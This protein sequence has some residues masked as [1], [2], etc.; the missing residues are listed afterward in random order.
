MNPEWASIAGDWLMSN[1]DG[2]NFYN[3]YT[4]APES[5]HIMWTYPLAPGGVVGGNYTDWNYYTGLAYE[6]KMSSPIVIDGKLILNLPLSTASST[7]GAVAID[8]HTGKQLWY[9]NNTR[10]SFAQ[11]YDYNSP[12]QFGVIPYLWST[13]STYNCYDPM[14]GQWLFSLNNALTGTNVFGPN[15]EILVYVLNGQANT[16]LKWNSTKA[17]MYYQQPGVMAGGNVWQWRPMMNKTMDWTKGIEW[18]VT[19]KTYNQPQTQSIKK[20]SPNVILSTTI[21]AF[22]LPYTSEMEIAYSTKDG[23]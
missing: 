7:G 5:G 4:S 13:G 11:Y 21:N 10:I 6:T 16:L 15:G 23:T 20:I 12:N 19:T 1:Y 18:N 14:T 22:T 9:Q 8:I 3:P 2:Y 17:I